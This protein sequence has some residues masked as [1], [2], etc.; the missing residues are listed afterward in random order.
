MRRTSWMLDLLLT[1]VLVFVRKYPS[2][3]EISL[4]SVFSIYLEFHNKLLGFNI[5]FCPIFKPNSLETKKKKRKNKEWY[6]P[7]LRLNFVLY[8]LV[9][10]VL[11]NQFVQVRAQV[12]FY[13]QSAY[14]EQRP[15]FWALNIEMAFPLLADGI[16]QWMK[17]FWK[18]FLLPTW[19]HFFFFQ[20]RWTSS[21]LHSDDKP[22][23][24]SSF[25]LPGWHQNLGNMWP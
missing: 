19:T 11:A 18:G 2:L 15:P 8:L 9:M 3:R 13:C 24:G 5:V 17:Q 16:G 21:S 23:L 12:E 14:W 1:A 10:G 7:K 6:F 22:C 25:H 4:S 20:P